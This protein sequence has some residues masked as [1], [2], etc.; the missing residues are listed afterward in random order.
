MKALRKSIL[1]V[2]L[3]FIGCATPA[4]RELH[5]RYVE[6]DEALVNGEISKQQALQMKNDA[7]KAFAIGGND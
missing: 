2:L 4:Q 7:H 1:L 6:I 3:G 5:S